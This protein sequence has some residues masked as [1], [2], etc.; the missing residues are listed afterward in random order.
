[1]AAGEFVSVRSQREMYEYQIGLERDELNEYPKQEAE[2]LALIYQAKGLTEKEAHDLASKLISDPEKAL[3]TLAREELGLAPELLGSPWGAA[4]FSFF[5]FAFGAAIPLLP[6]LFIAGRQAL[7]GA[8]GLT[9]IALF[10]VG[11][12]LTLFTG[13]SAFWGGIRMLAIGAAAGSV[14]YLIGSLM[15]ISLN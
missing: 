1:M 8:I 3:D 11:A 6:F 2:E 12:S 10:I 7:F 4:S 15:G 9:T 5:S 13:K 14:T